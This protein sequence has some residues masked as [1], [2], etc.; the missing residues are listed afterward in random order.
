MSFVYLTSLVIAIGCICLIDLRYK[1]AFWFDAKRTAITLIA[2]IFLFVIWDMLGISFGIFFDGTS[3]FMLPVRLLPH[4][5]LEEIFFL[6]LL[7]YVTL[8]MYKGFQKLWQRI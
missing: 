1:L 4:F 6:F 3:Q 8:V 7:T 2:S 5:P